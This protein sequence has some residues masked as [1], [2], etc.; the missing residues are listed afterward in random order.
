M[1]PTLI[2]TAD[3]G[4]ADLAQ[5]EIRQAVPDSRMLAEL[6]PGVWSVSTAI[7]FT[8]L[9]EQWRHQPPIFV[10]HICPVQ[11]TV[12]L[13][14]TAGDVPGLARAI[15]ATF[16]ELID[17]ELPFSVQARLFAE[18][19]YKPFDINATLSDT[20]QTVTGAPLNVR[21]P[22]QILSV[23]VTGEV[24]YLGLSLAIHNLSDWAGGVHRFARQKGQISRAEFKLLEALGVFR[25]ELPPRGIALDLGAAPGGWTRILRQR[26]QYVTAVDPADLHPSLEGDDKVRH[27]RM[28]AEAYLADDPGRFDIIVND[29]RQ[30]ARDSAR[31][32]ASYRRCLYPGGIGLMTFKLPETGRAQVLD[33]AF[34]I[35]RQVYQIAGARQL[36]HNRSEITVYLRS[37]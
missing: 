16:P 8:N 18:T 15:K 1:T 5:A 36:F 9:A 22:V 10:R 13:A 34:N 30:D 24:A 12:P 32:M 35:L 7:P 33:H 23:V 14:G 21:A 31:L 20:I 27:K 28:T 3:P 4:F 2:L 6:S 17:P 19:G 26:E 29:M 25:I 11:L 37:A